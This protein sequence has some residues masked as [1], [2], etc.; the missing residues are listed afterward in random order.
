MPE[1]YLSRYELLEEIGRG[2][3][4]VVYKARDP[5]LDRILAIKVV[6]LGFSLDDAQRQ[7]FLERF[8]REAK[9]AGNL[10][11]PHIVSVY[12]TDFTGD[13]PFIAMEYFPGIG[14]SQLIE[15]GLSEEQE[16]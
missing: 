12:D 16:T 1:N 13:E 6:R 2:N 11:H 3:M 5:E 4:G 15:R 8:R 7:T 14:L 10:L 9:I